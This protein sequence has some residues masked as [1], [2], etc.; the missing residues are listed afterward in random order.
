MT[1]TA[2]EVKS[3]EGSYLFVLR[4]V[5]ENEEDEWPDVAAAATSLLERSMP[6]PKSGQPNLSLWRRS[7][8]VRGR[9]ELEA[10]HPAFVEATLGSGGNGGAAPR[11]LAIAQEVLHLLKRPEFVVH[12][13]GRTKHYPVE[14]KSI[15]L[16]LQDAGVAVLSIGWSIDKNS[17]EREGAILLSTVSWRD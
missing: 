16:C 12:S 1:G 5:G 13:A 7:V 11:R 17:K 8:S 2:V 4:V 9:T 14:L 15:D 6:A 3:V 10:L